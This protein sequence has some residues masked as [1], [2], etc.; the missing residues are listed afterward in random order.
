LTNITLDAFG[1]DS[2]TQAKDLVWKYELDIHSDGVLDS[3]GTASTFSGNVPMGV[4][5][6]TWILADQ[7][8]NL[9]TCL[10]K[11]KVADCKKPSPYCITSLTQTL[12]AVHG[13]AEIWAKDFDKG[14]SDNCTSKDGLIFTFNGARPVSNRINVLHYFKENGILSTPSEYLAGS[15]QVWK[16]DTKSAGILFDCSDIPDGKS[17]SIPLKMT[18][19]DSLGNSDFCEVELI[20]QDNSNKCPDLI[21]Q[22]VVSGRVITENNKGV[23]DVQVY[24]QSVE[25]DDYVMTHS[26]GV[27]AIEALPL[28][29]E[30]SIKPYKDINPLEGV[31]AL[32]LVHI[33]R[34]I[35]GITLLD[36]PFKMIAA[37]ANAS[38][39]IT[40]G[41]LLEIRRLI[42]G[43][44]DKF[45]KG[46]PSWVFV[47]K[48]G[49]TNPQ[50]PFNY[51]STITANMTE[52][53]LGNQD[54]TAVKIGDV[55][56]SA[57]NIQDHNLERRSV[58]APFVIEVAFEKINGLDTW[59]FK[60]GSDAKF[61]A[62]QLFIHMDEA[63]E[64]VTV[65][66]ND[67]LISN[68]DWHFADQLLRLVMYQ[69]QSTDIQRND[70]L[71]TLPA[72]NTNLFS[73]VTTMQSLMYH[74]DA[75]R[76]I[77]LKNISRNKHARV[78]L[79]TNPVVNELILK[80]NDFD[81]DSKLS[82]KIVNA[83]G[84]EILNDQVSINESFDEIH[85]PL[86]VDIQSGVYFIKLSSEDWLETLKFI[87]IQ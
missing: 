58:V 65:S 53:S 41:D 6:I 83:E 5:T 82:Y 67:P 35:L 19:F 52:A 59:V 21:T 9:A 39:S 33:Q 84:K 12:D 75:E 40:A 87:R 56:N 1:Q 77:V 31:T 13:T 24:Y 50:N 54:F 17:Q 22:G 29:K 26:D 71:F 47:A 60:A 28:Q 43:I 48:D 44:T 49:I 42:L 61:D 14:S 4:H 72:S 76:P 85:I 80:V 18:V 23:S 11:V 38:K 66:K 63:I 32:D 57:L 7:C 45:P 69:N 51:T 74:D 3:N 70:I 62:L 68:M 86:S 36:S 64:D 73:L 81:N 16:P 79:R 8:G 10:R 25:L 27:F 34:H 15:A 55:N 46:L 20:L 78:Q 30:Y 37:D 2:C